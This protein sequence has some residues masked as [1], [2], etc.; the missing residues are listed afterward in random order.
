[1]E[2]KKTAF[3]NSW[4][5]A[6]ADQCEAFIQSFLKEKQ[7]LPVGDFVGGIVPH[8]GWFYSGSI[9]C[10]V[11]AALQ[12]ALETYPP[13]DTILL[14]G[15]HM[16]PQSEPFILSL[17]GVETPFGH[18]EVDTD[19][20]DR[21]CDSISISRRS[22]SRFP[23]D[24]TLELQYPF[25]KY[26]FPRARIVVCAVAPSA[27]SSTIGSTAVDAAERLSR[28]FRVI[29]STDMTHYGPDF[30]FTPEGT[31]EPAMEWVKNTNDRAAV[32]AMM[33]MDASAIISQG[34][35]NQNMCCPGAVAAAVAAC[36]RMGVVKASRLD[37]ATS[38]EKSGGSSFVGYAGIL[39]S[40]S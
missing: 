24:N 38:F 9:A 28:T 30:G 18:I 40:L 12:P 2:I 19:L 27:F 8:A 31:G 23:D 7:G 33:G 21:I 20:V 34:L 29:G 11:I 3:A 22:P 32:E 36:K 1:M 35:G 37:Y 39:Y 25:I 17:G 10:R 15:A 14:F 5:P 4:Y 16:H 6:A 13:I 26:F